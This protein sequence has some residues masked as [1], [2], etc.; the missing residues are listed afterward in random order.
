MA[1]IFYPGQTDYIEK[2]NLLADT[3]SAAFV[4]VLSGT[5]TVGAGTY[6]VQVA[7]YTRINN[8]ISFTLSLTWS[9]HSGTGNLIVTGLPTLSL[10]TA[11][12]LTPV[13][14]YYNSITATA[15]TV[16]NGYIDPNSSNINIRQVASSGVPALVPMD[17]AGSLLIS[18]TYFIS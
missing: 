1:D 9:A 10:N 7:R 6:S 14:V 15:A 16:I 3:V 12:L 13:T 17:T 8:T 11:N 2:L 18:G 5:T 4:P